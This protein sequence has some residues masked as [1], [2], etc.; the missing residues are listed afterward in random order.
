M[1]FW[2]SLQIQSARHAHFLMLS[3]CRRNC[4]QYTSHWG[5]SF[6]EIG[7]SITSPRVGQCVSLLGVLQDTSSASL[8]TPSCCSWLGKSSSLFTLCAFCKSLK[9]S[10]FASLKIYKI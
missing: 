9:H 3:L 1:G 7:D 5:H 8:V 6:D 4:A 2:K 10:S